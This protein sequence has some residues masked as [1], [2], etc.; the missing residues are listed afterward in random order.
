MQI[1]HFNSHLFAQ[2]SGFEY[3]EWLSISIWP[4]DGTLTSTTTPSQSG[5]SNDIEWELSIP[6]SSSLVPYPGQSL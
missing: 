5:L 1:I 2:K 6:Q 3:R 4:V